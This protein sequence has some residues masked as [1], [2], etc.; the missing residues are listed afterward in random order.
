M[1]TALVV[2]TVIGVPVTIGVVG[3]ATSGGDSDSS[4]G[5]G[6]GDL[7]TEFLDDGLITTAIE[8]AESSAAAVKGATPVELSVDEYGLTITYYDP[9]RDQVRTFE[10][11]AYDP[12]GYQVQ[13]EDNY[14]ED[15]RPR[16]LPLE[17]LDPAVFVEV[18][19]GAIEESEEPYSYQ[20]SAKADLDSGE[21]RIRADV[22]DGGG[23][24]VV[25]VTDADGD[26]VER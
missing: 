19:E 9:N 20:V 16:P 8:E 5:S 26:V 1:I 3:A 12:A 22:S 13:V 4:S 15:Y 6:F 17:D 21:L 25:E 7:D 11:D 2:A 10:K 18:G 14:F 23:D 24:D